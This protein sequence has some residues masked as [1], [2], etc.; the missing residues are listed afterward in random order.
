[1]KYIYYDI[2]KGREGCVRAVRDLGEYIAQ[3]A[4]QI[5]PEPLNDVIDITVVATI[6]SMSLGQMAVT[7]NRNCR[8]T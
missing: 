6:S 4:E 7:V 3:T 5:V 1:M 8:L 2:N